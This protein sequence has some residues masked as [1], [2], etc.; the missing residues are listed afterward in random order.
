MS[1][2][3]LRL[4][5]VTVAFGGLRAVDSL[6]LDL[7]SDVITALIG[8]NGA[9]KTTVLNA[10]CG[11]VPTTSGAIVLDGRPLDGAAVHERV[12]RG[13][14]RSFQ[15]PRPFGGLT[16]RE[17]VMVAVA[18]HRGGGGGRRLRRPERA[19]VERQVSAVLAETGL[20]AHGDA[21][22]RDLP[23][24]LRKRI[25]L[26]RALATE[27]R[28]LLLD[29]PAAG[30]TQDERCELARLIR[31]LRH[32]GRAILVIDHDIAFVSDIADVVAALDF[33]ALVCLGSLQ[34]VLSDQ[35]VVDSYLGKAER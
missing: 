10:V 18:A 9:G 8:A 31:G 22:V 7:R 19:A 35:R 20:A 34:E 6:S 14:G 3:P 12:R 17:N 16:V 4:V 2:T 28:V 30:L 24:G 29:E 26:A 5:D 15:T 27:P 32:V 23:F 25:E 13:I 11:V 21:L 1:E 33:G